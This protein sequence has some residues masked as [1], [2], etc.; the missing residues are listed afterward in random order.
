MH[1]KVAVTGDTSVRAIYS[2]LSTKIKKNKK[3]KKK[4]PTKMSGS[5]EKLEVQQRI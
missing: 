1:K 2:Y 3:I 5:L 4:E